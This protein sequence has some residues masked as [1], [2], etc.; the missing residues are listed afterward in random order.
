MTEQVRSIVAVVDDDPTILESLESLLEAAGYGVLLFK[1]AIALLE[2]GSLGSI[3]CLISDVG[4]PAM[5]GLQLLRIVVA[6]RP[7]LAV[8]LITGDRCLT[9]AP[10]APHSAYRRVFHKPF[11]GHRLLAAVSE[12]VQA[13][14]NGSS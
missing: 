9:A 7:G 2:S 1:S 6:T 4:L 10:A 12:A 8:L 13:T 5:D 3:D 14:R 11:D